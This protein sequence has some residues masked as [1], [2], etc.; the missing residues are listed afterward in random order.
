MF[1]SISE[2]SRDRSPSAPQTSVLSPGYDRLGISLLFVVLLLDQIALGCRLNLFRVGKHVIEGIE[3]MS[4]LVPI[5]L[6]DTEVFLSLT[7]PKLGATRQVSPTNGE[8]GSAGRMAAG[9]SGQ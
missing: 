1:Q 2:P 7:C 4:V 3:R 5:L 9:V 6:E 8:I